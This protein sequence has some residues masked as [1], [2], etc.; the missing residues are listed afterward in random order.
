MPTTAL[1]VAVPQ[2]EQLVGGLRRRFDPSAAQGVPPHVTVLVPFIEGRFLQDA[3]L[4]RLHDIFARIPAFPYVFASLGRF[5]DTTF[6]SPQDPLPFVH[7]TQEVW[8]AYPA[9]PPYGGAHDAVVPH[10]TVA[11]GSES[12]AEAA[13]ATLLP[14]VTT[15]P[16]IVG[17]CSEVQLIEQQPG[18][19]QVHRVFQLA[20]RDT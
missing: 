9:F 4:F 10:L 6:L 3:D 20:K 16:P 13:A 15:G 2:A 7:L 11:D 12:V 5:R 1:I 18:G 17:R 8:A 19:W 14:W